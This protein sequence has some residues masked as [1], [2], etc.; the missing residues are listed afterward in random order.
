MSN[1]DINNIEKIIDDVIK[2]RKAKITELAKFEDILSG[3]S[4]VTESV[5]CIL[6]ENDFSLNELND[7]KN[8]LADFTNQNFPHKIAELKA[9]IAEYKSFYGKDTINIG[10]AGI[11][12]SGKSTFLQ[13]VSGLNKDVIPTSDG[14]FCTGAK[15]IIYHHEGEPYAEVEYYTSDEFIKEAVKK[16]LKEIGIEENF[17]NTLDEF[18]KNPLPQCPGDNKSKKMELYNKLKIVHDNFKSF[19]HFLNRGVEKISIDQVINF[20]AKT[21]NEGKAIHEYNAVKTVRIYTPFQTAKIKK[22][23]LVDLPGLDE[24]A[25]SIKERLVAS[26]K[27]EIDII[28]TIRKPDSGGDDWRN[29]D[30]GIFELLSEYIETEKMFV[31]LNKLDNDANLKQ[32]NEMKF[33]A[34]EQQ[35]DKNNKRS[36]VFNELFTA[37]CKSREDIDEKVLIPVLKFLENNILRLDAKQ[38][39]E[40]EKKFVDL[41]DLFKEFINKMKRQSSLESEDYRDRE[42]HDFDKLFKEFMKTLRTN[43]QIFLGKQHKI[44]TDENSDFVQDFKNVI[45]KTCDDAQK[46]CIEFLPTPEKI[47]NEIAAAK[48]KDTY[49]EEQFVELRLLFTKVMHKI[50]NHLNEKINSK[51]VEIIEQM[52]STEPFKKFFDHYIQNAKDMHATEQL[53]IVVDVVKNITTD[54]FE[55]LIN[56]FNKLIYFNFSYDSHLH[57]IVREKMRLLNTYDKIDYRS[58][59][60]K[61]NEDVKELLIERVK[62][63]T[64]EVKKAMIELNLYPS[65]SLYA[66]AEDFVDIVARDSKIEDELNILMRKVKYIFWP[67]KYK[68]I[69]AV[70]EIRRKIDVNVIAPAERYL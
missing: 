42:A 38:I 2:I 49:I 21:N 47:E 64:F 53:K 52:K 26:L 45:V 3:F 43:L 5:S 18:E 24:I 48:G 14:G 60:I 63:T 41:K 23:A 27:N 57:Y 20:V 59:E 50:D 13:T 70:A 46:E 32:V 44:C 66:L 29:N 51:M 12:R 8:S 30:F 15:S 35:K 56:V 54:N 37:S 61:T 65:K 11:A 40:L 39:E 55:S 4:S 17:P 6:N 34:L 58:E 10:V 25:P 36:I 28:L 16:A 19:K 31:V 7:V 68:T 62:Q 33:K 22:L 1:I 67:E 9:K 69:K